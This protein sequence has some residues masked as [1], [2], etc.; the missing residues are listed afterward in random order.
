M[1][2]KSRSGSSGS[3]PSPHAA[4]SDTSEAVDA[5]MSRLEHPSKDLLQ[6]IRDAILGAAP[7]ISEGVKW[8]APS[9]RTHEYFAT[10]NLR[11][12]EGIGVILHLGAK[13]RKDGPGGVDVQDA[14]HLLKWHAPD[15]ASIRFA[16]ASDFR[17]K[18][19][20]FATIVR[21]WIV[22]V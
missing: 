17:A 8:N 13:V 3:K 20:A 16:S 5:F 14:A 2:A 1:A 11:E 6:A 19:A 12:K 7:G 9:F 4:A 15:R 22:H 21:N 10:T 18:R